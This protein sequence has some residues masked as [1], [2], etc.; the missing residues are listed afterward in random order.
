M[1]LTQQVIYFE[2]FHPDTNPV[3][4]RVTSVNVCL[5][6]LSEDQST[7]LNLYLCVTALPHVRN[8]CLFFHLGST[9]NCK[10]E[11]RVKVTTAA[12]KFKYK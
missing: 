2:V 6:K 7:R 10:N 11:I 4:R 1:F 5:E 3:G 8:A 12:N 9:L